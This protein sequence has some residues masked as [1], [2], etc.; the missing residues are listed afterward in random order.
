MRQSDT[1]ERS[2]LSSAL[3]VGVMIVGAVTLLVALVAV[4]GV[5]FL[6]SG[7][8]IGMPGVHHGI[9][10]SPHDVDIER[11]DFI[12]S[13]TVRVDVQIRNGSEQPEAISATVLFAEE[14]EPGRWIARGETTFNVV[15]SAG[16]TMLQR[17]KFHI[18]E[19]AS[20]RCMLPAEFDGLADQ[21]G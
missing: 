21:A 8:P 3:L 19:A 16:E 15:L 4:A 2:G 7:G 17:D 12:P 13:D 10:P 18:D 20:G 14:I 6:R 9:A 1:S 5:L 11:C